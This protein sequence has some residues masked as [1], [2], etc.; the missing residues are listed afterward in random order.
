M[1]Q[2]FCNNL[3]YNI[4]MNIFSIRLREERITRGY[5]QKQ[6]ANYLGT[7]PNAITMYETEKREPS[8][9]LFRRICDFFDIPADYLLGRTDSY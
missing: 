9:T 7:T 3:L 4:L 8:L 6:L 2:A 1:C 5:T